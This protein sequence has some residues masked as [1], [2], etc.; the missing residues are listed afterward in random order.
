M[1]STGIIGGGASGMMAAIAAAS[2]GEQVTILERQDRVGKKLLATGNGRCNL[3]NLDFCVERDYRSRSDSGQISAC[4]DRFGVKD[5]LS[6]FEKRGLHTTEKNGYLYPRSLQA[7]AVLDFFRGELDRLR[8]RVVCSCT[9]KTIR[10]REKFFVVTDQG[11]FCFDRLIL[12]CGSA[13]GTIAR[14]KLGGF[15]LARDLGLSVCE[16]FPALTALR[17][18]EKFMKQLAGVRC[19]ARVTLRIYPAKTEGFSKPGQMRRPES[20][21]TEEGELQLTDTCISGIPVFQFSRYAVDA[22]GHGRQ[23]EALIDFLPEY[24]QQAWEDVCRAQYENCLGKSVL[25]LGSGLLHKKVVCV[26]LSCCGLL[27]DEIV[28][29]K[30]RDRIFGMYSLMRA[31]PVHIVGHHSMEHAQVCA[32]GVALWEVDSHMES[33]KIPDLFL[34][35]EMLDVD[36][37]CGG[38]NLQW[39]WSSGY[40]AGSRGRNR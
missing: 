25:L 28:G 18:Q 17:C 21:Y 22:L 35:G 12:A 10:K 3:S 26:L 20:T 9:V 14:A 19:M 32:G 37:R 13:A 23:V 30:T 34:C 15:L 6:F 38:Y 8:V 16:P 36:G 7:A 31:F 4:F 33:Q 27:P 1:K 39:A 11:E 40:L 2:T 5:T 24:T 29:R